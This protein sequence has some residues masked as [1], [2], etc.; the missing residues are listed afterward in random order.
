[1][2]TVFVLAYGVP[3]YSLLH[4]VESF[5][6]RL[7]RAIINLAYW[8]IFGELEALDDIESIGALSFY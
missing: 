2:L 1:M 5:T 8:Q 3:V 7:P 4:D 6:W